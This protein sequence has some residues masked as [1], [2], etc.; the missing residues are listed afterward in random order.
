MTSPKACGFFVSI[1]FLVGNR[2]GVAIKKRIPGSRTECITVSFIR[3][4]YFITSQAGRVGSSKKNYPAVKVRL[5]N[6]SRT[7]SLPEGGDRPGN[8]A[9]GGHLERS[10]V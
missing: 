3:Q 5:R 10:E 9:I 7:I 6:A 2:K 1:N 8:F 4:I